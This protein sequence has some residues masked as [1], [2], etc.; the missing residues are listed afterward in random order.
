MHLYLPIAQ[1]EKGVL[2]FT[3]SD[4]VF[5]YTTRYLYASELLQYA[6]RAKVKSVTIV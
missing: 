3:T 4:S 6:A 5:G 2:S 1:N